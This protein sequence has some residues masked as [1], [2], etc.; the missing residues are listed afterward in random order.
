MKQTIQILRLGLA[1]L[2]FATTSPALLAAPRDTGIQGRAALYISHGI[3]TE[4]EPGIWVSPGDVM[5]PVATSFT[6]LSARSGHKV[7]RFSTDSDGTFTVSLRPGRYVV[8]PDTL[9]IGAFPFAHSVST[10]SFEVTVR[11]K[12]FTYALILYYQAGPWSIASSQSP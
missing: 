6:V 1:A 12:K 3:G 5:L 2:L 8:V 7:G 10:G 4:V 11:A 9:T